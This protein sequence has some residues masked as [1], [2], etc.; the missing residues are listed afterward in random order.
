VK[1]QNETNR[2]EKLMTRK[3]ELV[4]LGQKMK[5][6]SSASVTR[7]EGSL[8]T[9]AELGAALGYQ[10]GTSAGTYQRDLYEALGYPETTGIQLKDYLARYARQDIAKAIIDRPVKATWSGGV[11][12]TESEKT[13][14]TAFEKAWKDLERKHSLCSKFLRVDKL[15]GLGEYGV[16]LLGLSDVSNKDGLSKPVLTSSNGKKRELLYVKPLSQSSAE[17]ETWDDDP[18]SPRYGYPVLYKVTIV[19]P[20]TNTE[21][22]L[23]VHYTRM[24]HIA[25]DLEESEIKGT[26]RLLAVWNRLMDLEKIMGGSA[27]M[28][29]RGARPGYAA[30]TDPDAQFNDDDL[31]ELEDQLDEYEHKLRRFLILESMK[32]TPLAMQVADPTAH[33]DT[34]IQAISAITGIPKRI[35]TGS[36]RGELASTEDRSAWLESI[37]TRRNMFAEPQIVRAFADMMIAYG[38]LPDPITGDYG[39]KWEDPFAPSEEE[40]A[41][42]GEVRARALSYY[43]NAIGARDIVTEE[44]FF[45]FFMGFELDDIDIILGLMEKHL[46]EVGVTELDIEE[47]MAAAKK[48]TRKPPVPEEEE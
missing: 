15:T 2:R 21:R 31:D 22:Q 13:E 19:E 41:R 5:S 23:Q 20:S 29:W 3:K 26:P 16:L 17:I 7:I 34:Q 10:Y 14:E 42:I 40:K 47:A 18:S 11:R 28:F 4:T 43:A 1:R 35:L 27:E 36:E 30:T 8:T 12:L 33:V 38:I 37:K 9:R 25:D 44:A 45:K 6:M 48:Q 46:E 24:V 32:I 39:L